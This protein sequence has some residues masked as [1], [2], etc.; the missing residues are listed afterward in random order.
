MIGSVLDAADRERL[1]ALVGRV[2]VSTQQARRADERGLPALRVPS[3]R[4]LGGAARRREPDR[5]APARV[6]AAGELAARHR[7]AG[8]RRDVLRRLTGHGLGGVGAARSVP[9]DGAGAD[10]DALA[11]AAQRGRCRQRAGADTTRENY[12]L[13]LESVSRGAV[14]TE[15]DSR[16]QPDAMER[17]LHELDDCCSATS[18][19]AQSFSDLRSIGGLLGEDI[20]QS[21]GRTLED[22]R[23]PCAR[24]AR[25]DAASAAADSARADEVSVGAAAPPRRMARRALRDGASGVHG[26]G[27]RSARAGAAAG[28]RASARRRRSALRPGPSGGSCRAR[29]TKPS[30]WPAG[31][32]ALG[33]ESGSVI[34]FDRERDARIHCRLTSAE[35]RALLRDG[36]YDIVHFAGH[37]V[38]NAD[39]PE[40]SAWLLSDGELWALEIRNT[41]A[42]HPAP[43]WLV[44]ANACEAGMDGARPK[45]KYQGN[46]FGLATAFINQG[47]AAY[48]APLWPIDDLLAQHIALELLRE[49]LCERTTLGEALRRAK[50][51]ARATSRIRTSSVE[52]GTAIRRGPA[53][54]WASLVLYGDPTEELFQ[55]LA[56]GRIRLPRRTY[57]RDVSTARAPPTS[58]QHQRVLRRRTAVAAHEVVARDARPSRARSHRVA[59]GARAELARVV[60]RSTWQWQWVRRL[61]S[62]ALESDRRSR[63]AALARAGTARPAGNTRGAGNGNDGL[64]GSQIATLLADDR[65]RGCLPSQARRHARRRTLGRQRPQGRRARSR[66]RVRPRAG[67]E[68]GAPG[69]QRRGG[70][71][72]RSGESLC[73]LASRRTTRTARSFSCTAPS[74]RPRLPS[75]ASARRSSTGRGSTIAPCSASITGRCRSRRTR[76]RSSWR[77]SCAPSIPAC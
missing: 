35:M 25:R 29:A 66:P 2:D 12:L 69:R 13:R 52:T 42:D 17:A 47:V 59:L 15:Q 67:E 63:P 48:I 68:R 76:T 20:F 4:P 61:A 23:A 37:G 71:E 72:P 7:S 62:S 74:A 43:P 9:G 6:V 53:L 77:T 26:D 49:L 56:G 57:A 36:G 39:D 34:D 58:R 33:S 60:V 19:T 8:T 41:L 55:A 31:S 70:R 3:P 24:V 16:V 18:M 40:T 30:R 65:V 46:V 54:G 28:P 75:R 27:P 21:L 32:S 45:R 50:A 1:A 44:F 14:I 22:E 64:P 51:R 11:R 38:F 5:A 10:A 73:R